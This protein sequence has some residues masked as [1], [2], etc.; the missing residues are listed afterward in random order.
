M[1]VSTRSGTGIPVE[2]IGAMAAGYGWAVLTGGGPGVMEA[3]SRGGQCAR[4]GGATGLVMG[5]LPGPDGKDEQI[6]SYRLTR[7]R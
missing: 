3:A 6:Q 1:A 7:A 4:Q 2:V 5:I